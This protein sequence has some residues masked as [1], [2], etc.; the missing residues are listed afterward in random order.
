MMGQRSQYWKRYLKTVQFFGQRRPG[1]LSVALSLILMMAT[2]VSI[3]TDQKELADSIAVIAFL[4][5]VVGI[6]LE[7]ANLR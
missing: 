3:A 5:L 7:I 1:A 6:G 4:F 2:A